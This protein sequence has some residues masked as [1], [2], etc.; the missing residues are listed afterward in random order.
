M[1]AGMCCCR[2]LLHY[3]HMQKCAT[4]EHTHEDWPLELH[5]DDVIGLSSGV[6][7]R[8]HGRLT[9]LEQ[10]VVRA[11][12]GAHLVPKSAADGGG[13]RGEARRER[14]ARILLLVEPAHLLQGSRA[15]RSCCFTRGEPLWKISTPGV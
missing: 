13:V 5:A 6:I 15:E 2:V 8:M 12:S 10:Q 11:C 7:N 9:V 1:D 14:A 4:A 3:Y